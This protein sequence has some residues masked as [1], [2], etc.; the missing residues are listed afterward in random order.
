MAIISTDPVPNLLVG[1]LENRY[2][3]LLEIP[4]SF[5]DTP[6]YVMVLGGGHT[7]DPRLPVNDQL[8]TTALGRLT[9]GIR[10]HQAIP[11][12][13]LVLSGW[14]N[15]ETESQAETLAGTALLLGV[16]KE[17]IHTL[18]PPHNT[19]AEAAGYNEAFGKNHPLIVVTDAT[20]MPRAI[21]HFRMKGLNPIPAPTNHLLK[22]SQGEKRFTFLPSNSNIQKSQKVIHEYVGMLWAKISD[23]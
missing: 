16:D 15:S 22:E 5:P 21:M 20:H 4:Q 12:S 14:A 6:V 17:A 23:D 19:R 7:S 2:Q 13:R 11:G 1:S 8:S 3:T 10:I 18:P 9:E